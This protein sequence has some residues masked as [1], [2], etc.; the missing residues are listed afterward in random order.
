VAA[1]AQK[2]GVKSQRRTEKLLFSG[3]LPKPD[4]LATSWVSCLHEDG[5]NAGPM[6][7]SEGTCMITAKHIP[8]KPIGTL[9]EDRKDG[10]RLLLWEVDLPVIGRWDSD[11]E[12]WEHPESMHILEE[13]TYWA[14]INPPV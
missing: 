8:W 4:R 11:R 1:H 7:S 5:L 14:D 3:E 12:G 13:V 10:R 9:P 2:S 6:E